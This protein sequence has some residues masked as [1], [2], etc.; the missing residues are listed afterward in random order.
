MSS[1]SSA[2]LDALWDSVKNAQWGLLASLVVCVAVTSKFV[3]GTLGSVPF[4]SSVL[5]LVGV[6]AVIT[7]LARRNSESESTKKESGAQ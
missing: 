7:W 4:L 5:Q 6:V 2:L 3:S 1:A